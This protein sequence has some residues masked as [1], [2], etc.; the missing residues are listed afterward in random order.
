MIVLRK[1]KFTEYSIF[2]NRFR[3]VEPRRGILA[4][5][6]TKE[7]P[8]FLQ[9]AFR[10]DSKIAIIDDKG[11]HSYNKL[12]R[13]SM[14]LSHDLPLLNGKRVA[15]LT[16][17]DASYVACSWSIWMKG[18]IC[19]P[20]CKSHP[21]NEIDY[22]L[23]DS[24]PELLISSSE[25]SNKLKQLSKKLNIEH[26]KIPDD[27]VC[28]KLAS[29]NIDESLS[30]MSQYEDALM[31]YTSGTTGRPKGVLW[32]HDHLKKQVE[33]MLAAWEWEFDDT[34]LHVLPLHHFHGVV[35][36]LMC[37]LSI[38]ATIIMK[39][40]FEP[41]QVWNNLVEDVSGYPSIT[42]FMAV[43][44]IYVK[45]LQYFENNFSGKSDE[46]R[47]SCEKIRLM[48]SGSASLPT[49]IF[50]KWKTVTSHDLLERYGMTEIGMALTN[51]YH[52]KRVPGA[53]GRP[54]P[55]VEAKILAEEGENIVVEA[56]CNGVIKYPGM[57][58]HQG[59]LLIRGPI[60]KEYWNKPVATQEQF[61]K[62]GWF[63][64][65]DTAAFEDESFHIIGRTSVD[66]IKSGGYKISALDIE[67]QLLEHENIL[68]V[69]VLGVH[70]EIWGQ[71]VA[72]VIALKNNELNLTVE[73]L[74][75][76]AKELMPLYHIPTLVKLVSEIPKNAMG[77]VNKKSLL[78]LFDG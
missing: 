16:E 74:K 75:Q 39:N 9:K 65:G 69:A 13:L 46:V 1:Q 51:S 77:K 44:T 59:E 43:P 54:F 32:T 64:T 14:K 45:L 31:L 73:D 15:F 23:Q 70:D 68:E 10:Y 17:N 11:Q 53:V 47:K 25:H 22:V 4:N 18:G 29:I 3:L 37:P 5:T 49:K 40:Q 27:F 26:I 57:K 19:V 38:G 72:A 55:G 61:T 58:G 63:K 66:I 78:K 33:M 48:V 12:A 28:Q 67:R 60:F 2:Q 42:V 24:K 30:G 76:W 6:Q 56:N 34:I 7:L 62:D 35:N 21:V 36:A 8:E 50:D 41:E 52:G 71:R 20:I